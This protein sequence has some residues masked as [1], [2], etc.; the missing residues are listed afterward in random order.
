MAWYTSVNLRYRGRLVEV[1]TRYGEFTGAR[2]VAGKHFRLEEKDLKRI[3][4]LAQRGR[5]A[6]A[7]RHQVDWICSPCSSCPHH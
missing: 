2:V 3:Y 6:K 1:G 5:A 4:K 7:Y